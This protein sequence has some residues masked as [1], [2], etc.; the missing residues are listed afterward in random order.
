MRSLEVCKKCK[1]FKTGK[2]FNTKGSIMTC[3]PFLPKWEPVDYWHY[4]KKY[5]RIKLHSRCPFKMEQIVML[6]AE[7][8]TVD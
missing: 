1:W 2:D 3:N 5:A 8:K 7:G 4:E 6:G